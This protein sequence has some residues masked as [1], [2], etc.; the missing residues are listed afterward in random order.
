VCCSELAK[1]SSGQKWH[2]ELIPPDVLKDPG[3]ARSR[4]LAKM[5]MDEV[6]PERSMV[7]LQTLHLRNMGLIVGIAW[8]LGLGI[9]DFF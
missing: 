9:F 8:G 7:K 3:E 1:K 2:K 6:W 4:K 5:E